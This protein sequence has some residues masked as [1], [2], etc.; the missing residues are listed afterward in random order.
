MNLSVEQGIVSNHCEENFQK[1][2]RGRLCTQVA[3]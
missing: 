2:D 3:D 1:Y